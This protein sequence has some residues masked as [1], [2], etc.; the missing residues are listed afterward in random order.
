[1]AYNTTASLE[2]LTCTNYLD[3]GKFQDRFER[4]SWSK[5]DSNYLDVKLK[6][7]KDDN[8]KMTTKSSDWSKILQ[9]EKRILTSFCD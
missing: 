5:T 4:F 3:F 7:F 2:K 9:W 6:V 8:S 1:M